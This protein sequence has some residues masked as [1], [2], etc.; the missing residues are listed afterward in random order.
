MLE[1]YDRPPLDDAIEAELVE[2]IE[3]RAIELG[4]P[5]SVR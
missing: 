5:V 3:R 2:Y 4:D 1:S